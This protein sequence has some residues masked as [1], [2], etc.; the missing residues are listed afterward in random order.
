M[1]EEVVSN[2]DKIRST[3]MPLAVDQH[4][5]AVL[6]LLSCQNVERVVE[7]L[8]IHRVAELC[9]STGGASL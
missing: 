5:M 4:N 8:V 9:R 1:D 2:Y 3:A 7:W 6:R